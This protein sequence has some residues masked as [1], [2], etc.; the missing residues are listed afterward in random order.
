[1]SENETREKTDC[2]K[3]DHDM[4]LCHLMHEGFHYSKREAYKQL[5]QN[6]EFRCQGCARTAEKGAN[7]CSPASL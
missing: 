5:V 1:M 7:L 6:A 3:P 2:A 4:H